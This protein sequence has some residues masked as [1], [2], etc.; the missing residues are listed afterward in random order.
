MVS[1]RIL[2]ALLM[3]LHVTPRPLVLLHVTNQFLFHLGL[4]RR[5]LASRLFYLPNDHSGSEGNRPSGLRAVSLAHNSVGLGDPLQPYLANFLAKCRS[6]TGGRDPATEANTTNASN[7]TANASNT[8]AGD[9]I[10]DD[11]KAVI[12]TPLLDAMMMLE[13]AEAVAKI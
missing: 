12:D 6:E 5:L 10:A 9:D 4:C 11:I 8:A 1:S 13:P 7:T 3:H 2:I